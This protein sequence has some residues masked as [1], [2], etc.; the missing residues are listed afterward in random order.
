MKTYGFMKT[1]GFMKTYT[2]LSVL[3][4]LRKIGSLCTNLLCCN[5]VK[6]CGI[7]C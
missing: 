3:V 6:I 4:F 2:V 1:F 5:T 7:A